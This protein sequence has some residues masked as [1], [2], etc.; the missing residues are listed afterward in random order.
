MH[1][2][3]FRGPLVDLGWS[4]WGE[5]G[6]P[7]VLRAHSAVAVDLEPL[8]LLS[9]SLFPMEPRLRDQVYSWCVAH[10]G[11]V[12]V[13]RLRGLLS[14]LP[15]SALLQFSA[16]SAS[17]RRFDSIQWPGEEG[18]PWDARP[19]VRSM[20]LPLMR[21]SL[22]RL[23]ARAACGA[24]ARA[25]I[26]CELFAREDVWTR[27]SQVAA[28]I[29]YTARQTRQLLGDLQEAGLVMARDEGNGRSFCLHDSRAWRKIL[30]AEDVVFPKWGPIS[31]LVLLALTL[32]AQRAKSPRVL[33]VIAHKQRGELSKLAQRLQ[34]RAPPATE[35]NANAYAALVD[36]YVDC[37]GE[38]ADG[39][40]PAL[41]VGG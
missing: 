15:P 18:A 36:W 3:E 7:S 26:V 14:T 5:L 4:L 29:G 6:V 37:L 34:L 25:D 13:S 24:G 20:E 11:R 16:F 22:A 23:R 30:A 40:S 35:A 28:D 31:R 1:G 19:D 9:P 27:A 38:L 10:S 32:H 2:S 8:I 39:T 41:A 12:S 21:P 17:L 33:R